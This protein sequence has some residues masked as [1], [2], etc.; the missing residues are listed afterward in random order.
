[1]AVK[2][3]DAVESNMMNCKLNGKDILHSHYSHG[4]YLQCQSYM[5]LMCIM[6]D[7]HIQHTEDI[8]SDPVF[9]NLCYEL[10]ERDHYFFAT[11]LINLTIW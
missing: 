4:N 2:L 11:S 10:R 5:V 3:S 6:N 8:T 7:E 9:L 1:M